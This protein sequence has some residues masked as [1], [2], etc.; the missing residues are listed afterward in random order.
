MAV[1]LTYRQEFNIGRDICPQIES[2]VVV[3]KDRVALEIYRV[4]RMSTVSPLIAVKRYIPA[5]LALCPGVE[6]CPLKRS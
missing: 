3:N 4:G 5:L 1:K 2:V 6:H